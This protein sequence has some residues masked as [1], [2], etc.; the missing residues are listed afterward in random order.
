M[1][2]KQRQALDDAIKRV[3]LS[4]VFN[5]YK[6]QYKATVK[7]YAKHNTS[8]PV[9]MWPT[10]KAPGAR[11]PPQ[12]A[13]KTSAS[14]K[15]SYHDVVRRLELQAVDHQELDTLRGELSTAQKSEQDAALALGQQV[16]RRDRQQQQGR[17]YPIHIAES[18]LKVCMA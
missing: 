14:H 11:P 18:V 5:A 9:G 10:Q 2:G 4:A 3:P 8:L 7:V 6:L 15:S 17:D 16:E 1:T 13:A 12:A